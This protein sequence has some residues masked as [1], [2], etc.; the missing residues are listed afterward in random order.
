MWRGAW[1]D[2]WEEKDLR[3]RNRYS[4]I[5]PEIG[6]EERSSTDHDRRRHLPRR[7]HQ[8]CPMTVNCWPDCPSL[9]RYWHNN[10]G[11]CSSRYHVVPW[12]A[13]ALLSLLSCRLQPP[14]NSSTV[15]FPRQVRF[16]GHLAHAR[17]LSQDLRHEFH[18]LH[19][20]LS[21]V[22]PNVPDL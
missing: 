20:L 16:E 7:R 21:S 19:S 10:T 6:K 15:N 17:A 22:I 1:I 12:L 11:P 4:H 13:W 3:A 14:K 9:V 8:P 18:F 5:G 2:T